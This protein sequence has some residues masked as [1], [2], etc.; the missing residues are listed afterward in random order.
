MKKLPILNLLNITLLAENLFD[1][2]CPVT[3]TGNINSKEIHW[4]VP[5]E[6]ESQADT[7]TPFGSLKYV[8]G[9]H[10]SPFTNG[11]HDNIN[12]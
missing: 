6:N 10:S 7:R 4:A 8:T 1:F 5:Y 11:Y 2:V 12:I 3:N 9:S